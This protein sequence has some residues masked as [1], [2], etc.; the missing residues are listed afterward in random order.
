MSALRVPPRLASVTAE[1]RRPFLEALRSYEA[2]SLR[3][4][5]TQFTSEIHTSEG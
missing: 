3:S 4:R 2:T 5:P 1:L